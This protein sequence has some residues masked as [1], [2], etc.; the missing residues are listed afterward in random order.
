MDGVGERPPPLVGLD[1]LPARY[2]KRLQ[3]MRPG[4]SAFT[5]YTAS[6]TVDLHELGYAH[7]VFLS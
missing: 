6:S 5:V 4:L 7:E 1:Q 2:V 3:K